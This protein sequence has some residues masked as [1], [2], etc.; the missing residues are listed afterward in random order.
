MNQ[1]LAVVVIGRNEGERLTRCLQSIAA[2]KHSFATVEVIYVDSAS[3]DDSVTRAA[4]AGARVIILPP[5]PTTAARGRNAGWRSTEA[6]LVLF[7]DGDTVLDPNFVLSAL[8]AMT[9]PQVAIVWGHRRELAPQASLYNRV[10][11]LDWIYRPGA[12]EFCGGDALMRREVLAEVDGYDEQL[13]AGEEPE[14]CGRLRSRGYQIMH[15]DCAMTGHDLAMTSFRQYWKRATRAGFAY[16]EVSRRFRNTAQPLWERDA[17][18]NLVHGSVLL[19]LPGLGI[20]AALA[21]RSAIPVLCIA[22]ALCLLVV[23]TMRRVS[24]KSPGDTTTALLYAIHSHL[25]QIP[26]LFGQIKFVRERGREQRLIEYK[27]AVR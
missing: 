11:D 3:N 17:K 25:Q 23:R 19:C 5:G 14:M 1:S 10:L 12:S 24:W 15:I 2:M 6:A 21:M 18:R 26:I 22:L 4:Q 7:L 13:I 27:E 20:V 16:A 8:A 9:E